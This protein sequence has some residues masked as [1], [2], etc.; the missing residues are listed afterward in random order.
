M[1]CCAG[2]CTTLAAHLVAG[3]NT[4]PKGMR[5]GRRF[6]CHRGEVMWRIQRLDVAME[7]VVEIEVFSYTVGAPETDVTMHI[8]NDWDCEYRR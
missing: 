3:G 2:I 6:F 1:L 4:L 7:D 5:P 8:I